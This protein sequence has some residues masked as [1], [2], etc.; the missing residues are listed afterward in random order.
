MEYLSVPD[1]THIVQMWTNFLIK[2]KSIIFNTLNINHRYMN[3]YLFL[4]IL[5][6]LS[7]QIV[8]SQQANTLQGY[9]KTLDGFKF[10][11][12]SPLGDNTGAL[13]SRAQDYFTPIEWETEAVPV[14]FQGDEVTFIWAYGMDATPDPRKFDIYVNG[15][16]YF[17]I[18]N[19]IDN[20]ISRYEVTADNGARMLFHVTKIDKHKDQMGFT[21]LVLPR[22]LV[23]PGEPV[24]IKVDGEDSHS[25]VWY[26][27][28]T[29]K[30][31][32]KLEVGQKALVAKEGNKQF[33]VIGVDYLNIGKQSRGRLK[34]GDHTE[35]IDISPGANSY[36]V[37][38]PM[39]DNEEEIHI[40]FQ[41]GDEST[42]TVL[43]AFAQ[44]NFQTP[45]LVTQI[46]ADGSI[47]IAPVIRTGD[48]LLPGFGIVHGEN[49]TI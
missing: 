8:F 41:K 20:T 19:P 17:T 43:L 5:I 28:F 36:D 7:T 49:V 9:A 1:S 32:E 37:R 6:L 46:G 13:L 14:D 18:S 10:Q 44:V 33:H 26:M 38:V 12:H 23:T 11:Y 30:L 21:S 4:T 34:V 16:K 3:R 48:S 2:L 47:A 39:T 27:I 25:N 35:T 45:S 24:V 40:T 22:K 29:E 31:V 42:L 15:Q